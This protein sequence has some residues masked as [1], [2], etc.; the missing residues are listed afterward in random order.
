MAQY[1]FNCRIISRAKGQS[2]IASA[3]YRSG[4]KLYSERYGVTSFYKREVPP[5]TFI[6]KPNHAPNWTLDREKLWNGVE[7]QETFPTA[8][9]ARSFTLALPREMTNEQQRDLLEDFVQDQLVDRG[10]VADVAIHREDDNNP[11]AHILTTVRP[12]DEHGEWGDKTKKEYL[13]DEE[14][15]KQKT[16]AGNVRS[17]KVDLTG[18]GNKE[19]FKEWREEWATIQ[20]KHLEKLG[21]SD[22]VTDKSYV[23]QGI[24]KIPTIHEGYVARQMEQNGRKSD[25]VEI[26][27]TIKKENYEVE[28]TRN[29]DNKK[30]GIQQSIERL[31]DT[32]KQQLLKLASALNLPSITSESVQESRRLLSNWE[33]STT[34]NR[35]LGIA[36]KDSSQYKKIFT[37]HL[38]EA[39]EIVDKRND[40]IIE[41]Y[42]PE[43]AEKNPANY[44]KK[45]LS[46]ATIKE[47]R[48]LTTEEVHTLLSEA[49]ES[50]LNDRLQQ[51]YRDPYSED[52]KVFQKVF[53]KAR[54]DKE[55]FL[56][57]HGIDL[58]DF[59]ALTDVPEDVKLGLKKIEMKEQLAF[60]SIKITEQY[61][62]E[63]IR[64]RYP[65]VDMKQLTL[66]E[67]E[68]LSSLIDYYGD[69]FSEDQLIRAGQ[70]ELIQKYSHYERTLGLEYLNKFEKQSFT[71]V[72][73]AA[74]EKD[75][76]KKELF[77]TVADTSKRKLFLAELEDQGAYGEDRPDTKKGQDSQV[78]SPNSLFSFLSNARLYEHLVQASED[79]ARRRL[80]NSGDPKPRSAK[81]A[82]NRKTKHNRGSS[83]HY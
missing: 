50:Q 2:A 25:R 48:I 35:D 53:L 68:S 62:E 58:K 44:Y 60:E 7:K 59:K 67:K 36:V 1:S 83:S 46:E 55:A 31:L 14:G 16:A 54:K 9:L 82:P 56:E 24:K 80:E 13:L 12:F 8:Q 38:E 28:Y 30:T 40:R 4:E 33:R 20:N 11:H 74:I 23:E 45:V 75:P 77:H 39:A 76:F 73:L 32:D 47:D 70:K 27:R 66:H 57:T 18:W 81:K 42:Y 64:S 10:M 69:R 6:L 51:L 5:E 15:K 29:E 21:Y 3:S 41:T 17:R 26:N 63:T 71:E 72:E 78:S 79:N 49:K 19:I 22:R 34:I 65:T 61:F 43:V 37:L 52:I